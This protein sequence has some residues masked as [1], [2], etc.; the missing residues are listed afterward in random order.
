MATVMPDVKNDL[1]GLGLY[2]WVF[3]GFFL[4][5]L[6]GTVLAGELADRQG[7]VLP[8]VL[9]LV[10]FGV[11]LVVGGLATSMPMLIAG[12]LAQGL[13]AGAIPA[14]GYASIGRGYPA[15]LQ[16]RVFA[17]LSTAWVVPGLVGPAAAVG[18]EHAASWRWVFLALLPLVVLAGVLAVPALAALDHARATDPDPLSG[19]TTT[20]APR[21]RVPR[22]LVLVIG[23]GAVF[24]AGSTDLLLLVGAL[25][26]AGVLAAGWAFRGLVPP[27]TLRLASGVP[28][29]VAIRGVLTFTFFAADAYVPLAITDGRGAA[30]W[31]G[32]LALSVSALAWAI[33]SWVQARFV[34][35][36]GPRRLVRIGLILIVFATVL[37]ILVTRGSPVWVAVAAWAISGAGMGLAYAP[38]SLTVL[39]EAAPGEE[40]TASAAL[41]LSDA[42][43]IALGTGA[44]GWIVALA[45][46]RHWPVS[47]GTAGVFALACTV[48]LF[49]LWGARRL[50]STV[51]AMR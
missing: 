44:G 24:S 26:V 22:V 39:G 29:T 6:V 49:G 30:A 42:L 47:T 17:V 23:V 9:G 19:A 18:I 43:G 11:G 37:L 38:L 21:T 25:L 14:T 1:G 15:A 50:P 12:R 8:F 46:G 3:S 45:D 51:P 32:G 27:G 5:S 2:G 35:V 28:A 48:G 4:A 20:G 40:G 33:G 34:H 16:P 7:L 36:A 13:G 41:I 31:V 10:A